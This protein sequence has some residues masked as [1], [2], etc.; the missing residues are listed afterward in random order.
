MSRL[1]LGFVGAGRAARLMAPAAGRFD[2]FDLVAVADPSEPARARFALDYGLRAMARTEELIDSTD[3]D[4]LYI[5][6]PTELHAAHACAA[7][8]AGKHVLVEKPIAVDTAQATRII[9]TAERTGKALVVGHSHS[10]DSPIVLMSELI[11]QDIV[12]RPRMAHTWCFSDWFYRPRLPDEFNPAKGGGVA[13]RQGAHQFDVIRFLIGAE[14]VSVRAQ[15]GEWDPERPGVGAYTVFLSFAGGACATAA[16]SGYDGLSSAELTFGIGESGEILG[17]CITGAQRKARQGRSGPEEAAAK[18]LRGSQRPSSQPKH[19]PFFGLTVVLCERGDLRQSPNGV[20][21]Y[22]MAGRKEILLAKDA[23]SRINVLREFRDAIVG[24][25]K[26][27][28]SGAWGRATLEIC[29]AVMQS[30]AQGRE[31]RLQLQKLDAAQM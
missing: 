7:L 13:F 15:I 3:V 12:G 20:Y 28:H 11:R 5:A 30:A 23:D 25:E 27:L 4:A 2:G 22:S 10:F 17:D 31:V 24:K 29:E 18:R 26:P 8:R 19:S 14:P 16:Y 1:R 6:T 9:E 21:V